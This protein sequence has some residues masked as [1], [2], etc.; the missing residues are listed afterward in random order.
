MAA[1]MKFEKKGRMSNLDK[2]KMQDK[3]SYKKRSGLTSNIKAGA[4]RVNIKKAGQRLQLKIKT[5]HLI[6]S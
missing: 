1:R 3:N 6:S 4:D 2:I 5:G